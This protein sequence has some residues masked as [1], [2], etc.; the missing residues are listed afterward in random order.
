MNSI[1]EN[2]EEDLSKDSEEEKEL[3]GDHDFDDVQGS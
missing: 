3:G 2:S 1:V